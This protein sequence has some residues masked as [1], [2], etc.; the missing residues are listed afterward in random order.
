MTLSLSQ[1]Y[2]TA[3]AHNASSPYSRIAGFVF[4]LVPTWH[5]ERSNSFQEM[6]S[7]AHHVYG[8]FD[9]ALKENAKDCSPGFGCIS[10]AKYIAAKA[11]N[12]PTLERLK[13]LKGK[14]PPVL[15]LANSAAH[16]HPVKNG[17]AVADALDAEFYKVNDY[18]EAA[19]TWPGLIA[20][21]VDRVAQKEGVSIPVETV[22]TRKMTP[23]TTPTQTNNTKSA[24]KVAKVGQAA[25][26]AATNKEDN[27]PTEEGVFADLADGLTLTRAE[28]YRSSRICIG[29]MASHPDIVESCRQY[30]PD[31]FIAPYFDEAFC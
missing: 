2:A 4:T 12:S 10:F 3:H 27:D 25:A 17:Q 18:G 7:A 15:V 26:A 19:T 21:F 9:N 11:S 16:D 24:A 28:V 5:E 30:V 6:T 22:G 1:L 23:S 14:L 13:T 29:H 20:D 31:K 8:G